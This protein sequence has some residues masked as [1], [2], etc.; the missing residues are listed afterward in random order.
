MQNF[1]QTEKTKN[2]V[3]ASNAL[4]TWLNQIMP[5]IKQHLKDNQISVKKDFSIG[6]RDKEKLDALIQNPPKPISAW[7]SNCQYSGL[8]LETKSY[9]Q[10]SE[11]SVNYITQ[12]VYLKEIER[13]RD[14]FEILDAETVLKELIKLPELEALRDS[15]QSEINKIKR[16]ANI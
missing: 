10:V 8:K 14:E 5:A 13:A 15:I 3:A 11:H 6:K 12:T 9:Y 1:S 7:F 16:M 4:N 2:Y